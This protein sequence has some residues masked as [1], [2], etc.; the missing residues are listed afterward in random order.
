ML[1][2][3]VV[4]ATTGAFFAHDDEVPGHKEII[5]LLHG[6]GR[7]NTSMWLLASR[8]EDAGYY[9]QR[10]GYISLD[11]TPDQI[12]NDI[13]SQINRCCKKILKVFISSGIRSVD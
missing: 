8:L 12:L 10:V 6:L 7:S 11:Q 4:P 3:T 13:S 1:I 9:V 2:A 5:V